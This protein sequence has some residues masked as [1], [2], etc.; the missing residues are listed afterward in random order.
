ESRTPVAFTLNVA[1]GAHVA[2]ILR[3]YEAAS[4]GAGPRIV[5]DSL[6]D[7]GAVSQAIV[8]LASSH[9]TLWQTSDDRGRIDFGSLAPGHYVMSVVG[10]DVPEFMA[11]EHKHVEIDV[12]AGEQREVELRLLPQQRAVQFIGEET[13]L[14]ASPVKPPV[15]PQSRPNPH[16]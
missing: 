16:P 12:V 7:V 3:R 8:A 14:V 13:V 4:S 2:A 9:D 15:K 6:I 11:F 10:C 5:S 1:R